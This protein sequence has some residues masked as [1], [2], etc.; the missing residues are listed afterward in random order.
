MAAQAT[1]GFMQSTEP[2]RFLCGIDVGGTFTDLVLVDITHGQV[3]TEKIVTTAEDPSNAILAGLT[4]LRERLG[5]E[6]HD[7]AVRL[8]HATTLVTNALI[9]RRGARIGL[10]TTRGFRD[11][12]DFQRENR[13]DIF[14]LAIRFP[15]PLVPVEMRWEIGERIGPDGE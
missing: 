6:N 4:A 1:G 15:K 9:E 2:F 5:R 7:H 8:V 11:I 14:D 12:L 10:L 13:F 3:L